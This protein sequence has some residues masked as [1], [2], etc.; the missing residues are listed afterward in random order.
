MRSKFMAI[1]VAVLAIVALSA[2]SA[3]APAQSTL[4]AGEAAPALGGGTVLTTN[5]QTMAGVVVVGS[6][7][8]SAEPEIAEVIFG[9][10]LRG[11][12]PAALV[13]EAAG[14]IDQAIA[15][16]KESGVADADIRTTGYNLWVETVYDP[17][18]G[19]PTGEVIYH[20]SHYLQATVRDMDR[21]GGMLAAVVS[22]GANTISG[23]NFTVEDTEALIDQAR[24][25]ALKDAQARAE[26][27]AD[28]LGIEL[29]KPVQVSEV[30]GSYPVYDGIG[31]MGGAM[32]AAA[33]SI[34]PGS[35][36]VSV[37][38]QVVYEI[39]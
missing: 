26:A 3:L 29:G 8:A 22:A 15:A 35:F 36:S 34:V 25:D 7:Q 28:G 19:T 30:S 39:R 4:A 37:S 5:G 6:A 14:K 27:M 24:Q 20:I 32:E 11:D 23:V 13:D 1:G 38:I 2:C 9:V 16:A 33:P 10:E 21:L 17:D 18:R 31:G 12:D